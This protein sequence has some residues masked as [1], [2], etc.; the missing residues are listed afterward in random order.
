ML[1]QNVPQ[2]QRNKLP[3]NLVVQKL[4]FKTTYFHEF[5]RQHKLTAEKKEIILRKPGN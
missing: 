1:K 3:R 5:S 2:R 4:S